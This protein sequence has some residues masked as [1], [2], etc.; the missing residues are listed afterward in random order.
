MIDSINLGLSVSVIVYKTVSPTPPRKLDR[1]D[2]K[3][4]QA[5]EL[6]SNLK[7]EIYISCYSE[8]KAYGLLLIYNNIMTHPI[9]YQG[10]L[11]KRTYS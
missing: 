10:G 4:R 11:A 6:A 1:R 9:F 2:V 3:G 8:Y 7:I 5:S